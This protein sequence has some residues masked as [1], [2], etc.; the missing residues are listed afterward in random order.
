MAQQLGG[1]VANTGL[2]EY[3]A[4]EARVSAGVLFA[5]QPCEP[6]APLNDMSS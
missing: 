1:Q 6:M 2:R 3:G 4:T 5:E